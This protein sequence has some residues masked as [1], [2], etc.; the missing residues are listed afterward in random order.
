MDDGH[1]ITI[2]G[3][4]V[5]VKDGQNPMDAF[6]RQK[7]NKNKQEFGKSELESDLTDE[8]KEVLNYYVKN[9][10]AYDVNYVLRNDAIPTENDKRAIKDLTNAINKAKLKEDTEVYRYISNETVFEKLKIGEIYEDKG[11]MSTTYDNNTDREED[12]QQYKVKMIINAP[13]GTNALDV[14]KIFDSQ[15]DEPE[16]EIIFNKNTK[17]KLENVENIRDKYDEFTRKLYYFKITK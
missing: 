11:F 9:A 17:L 5:F 4:H 13:K 3:T 12:Y 8:D 15:T 16:R 1:W 6:I 14:S 2:N 7:A 10:G